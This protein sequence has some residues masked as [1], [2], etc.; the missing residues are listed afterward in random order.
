[1]TATP[2]PALSRTSIPSAMRCHPSEGQSW[3]KEEVPKGRRVG[4]REGRTKEER[5]KG[6]R[7]GKKKRQEYR[8]E[9]GR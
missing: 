5:K 7:E 6:R 8:R 3:G 1:M 9:R 4:G 2:L